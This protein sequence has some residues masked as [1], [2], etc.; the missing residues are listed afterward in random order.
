VTNR[1][2]EDEQ[3]CT[4]KCKE[5]LLLLANVDQLANKIEEVKNL[6]TNK[7]YDLV[8]LTY[9]SPKTGNT[10]LEDSHVS[11]PG[12]LETSKLNSSNYRRVYWQ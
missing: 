9:V 5:L 10:R 1:A 2:H 3:E 8:I 6:V 4:Q 11:I 7:G 12:Y